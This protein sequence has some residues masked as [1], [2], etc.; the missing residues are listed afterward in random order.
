[1]NQLF[2]PKFMNVLTSGVHKVFI[3][4]RNRGGCIAGTKK[5]VILMAWVT[6]L[7][8]FRE[9]PLSRRMDTKRVYQPPLML[10]SG[11]KHHTSARL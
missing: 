5:G 4:P 3:T 10:P 7:I 2:N 9:K 11:C 6:S 1:M 8:F